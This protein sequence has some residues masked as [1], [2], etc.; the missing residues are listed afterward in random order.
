[1]GE[2]GIKKEE[3]VVEREIQKASSKSCKIKRRKK[4]KQTEFVANKDNWKEK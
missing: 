3:V 1:V 4:L 2:N